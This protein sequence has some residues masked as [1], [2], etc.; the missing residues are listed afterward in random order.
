MR[1]YAIAHVEVEQLP[2]A[3]RYPT[4]RLYICPVVTN[5]SRIIKAALLITI[6]CICHAPSQTFCQ[7]GPV[8][9][10]PSSRQFRS[11]QMNQ[12]PPEASK[13]VKIS[14]EAMEDIM[15]LYEQARKELD[16]KPA[17]T[18]PPAP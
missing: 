6:C 16:A 7:S 1:F 11:H 15:R 2:P 18:S 10:P 9:A 14:A 3:G 12:P 4:P 13:R 5:M 17:S 8:N